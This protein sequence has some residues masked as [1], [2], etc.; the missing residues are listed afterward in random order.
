[1]EETVQFFVKSKI[2]KKEYELK[3][4]EEKKV[5]MSG[6]QKENGPLTIQYH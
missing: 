3:K 2:K 5:G 6:M 1:M 4:K